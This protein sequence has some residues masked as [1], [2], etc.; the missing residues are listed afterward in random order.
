MQT[1][2]YLAALLPAVLATPARVLDARDAEAWGGGQSYCKDIDWLISANHAS[3][4]AA[5]FCSSYLG[6]KTTTTTKCTT[7]TVTGS[8]TTATTTVTVSS[9]PTVTSTSTA[10]A[11]STATTTTY[12]TSTCTPAGSLSTTAAPM[13]KRTNSNNPSKWCWSWDWPYPPNKYQPPA[14]SSACSCVVT[15]PTATVTSTSTSTKP[16]PTTTTTVTT[17]VY[18]TTSTVSKCTTVTST[19]TTTQ[20]STEIEPASPTG[21]YS[22]ADGHTTFED[23]SQIDFIRGDLQPYSPCGCDSDGS[24]GAC[25]I[26]GYNY[27]LCTGFNS[28]QDICAAINDQNGN[29]TCV[30]ATYTGTDASGECYPKSS[31]EGCGVFA[32]GRQSGLISLQGYVP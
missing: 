14:I 32:D 8:Q 23:Y 28:C 24:G 25:V 22:A 21:T 17:T 11:T 29:L 31:L 5:T 20:T 1:F 13:Q 12:Y 10:T 9:T 2:V 15:T 27:G 18:P 4:Y 7:T 26:G 3:S 30:A 19:T 6:V 16:G